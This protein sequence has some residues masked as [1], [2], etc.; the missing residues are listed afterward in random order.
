MRY[1][2]IS[3]PLLGARENSFETRGR[4]WRVFQAPRVLG[5]QNGVK[6]KGLKTNRLDCN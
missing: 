1:P 2:R 5:F 6:N 4:F 3:A